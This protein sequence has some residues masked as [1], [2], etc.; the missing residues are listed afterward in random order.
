MSSNP[1]LL[2]DTCAVI[3]TSQ[4]AEIAP[5]ADAA[6]N[7]S[8]K[9][10]QTHVSPITAWELGMSMARGRLTSS[11]PALEFF[12]RYLERG[13]C[14]LCGL[15]PEMLVQASYLPGHFH[16]DPA[17]RILVATARTLDLVLV[18]RDRAILA[19]GAQGHVKTLAC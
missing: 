1:S 19:Y 8:A 7:S 2:L 16:R 13:G 11:L 9:L 12:N 10:G 14:R 3:F 18:T 4:Q 6:I 17:D 5:A 15:T